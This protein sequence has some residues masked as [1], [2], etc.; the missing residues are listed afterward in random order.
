[1]SAEI[2]QAF[3]IPVLEEVLVRSVDDIDNMWY[4]LNDSPLIAKIVSQDIAHKSDV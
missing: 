2:L 1:L 3:Q 4:Y